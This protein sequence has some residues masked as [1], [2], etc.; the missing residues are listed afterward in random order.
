MK[1]STRNGLAL[2]AVVGCLLGTGGIATLIL[3][4]CRFIESTSDALADATEGSA[5]SDVFR[6]S[7][8]LA[9]S[10]R[11]YSPA[12][13]HY[14]GRSVSAQIL[15]RYRVHPDQ[16]LQDYVNLVG[17]AVLAAPE[18]QRTLTG[19]HFIVLEG[20]EVQG[21][22][23]P[24]GFV[25]VTEGAVRA[26]QDEDELAALL[27]HEIAHVSLEHGI[28]AVKAATRQKAGV[29]LG[30]GAGNTAAAASGKDAQQLAELTSVFGNVVDEITTELLV[31]GYGR[32][33]ELAADATATTYLRSSGYARSALAAYLRALESHG[34]GG[35]GGWGATHPSPSERLN[36]LNAA[37]LDQ[38]DGVAGRDVRAT[39]FVAMLGRR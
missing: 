37:G 22:S 4:G 39:R 16:S 28:L 30:K 32:D 5:V 1:T 7:A 33:L 36:A 23:A 34:G 20:Q 21:V 29:L 6:G 27:A 11:E 26:A 24:G 8:R 13:E 10:Y 17:M 12:E 3:G 38:P 9:E 14:I 35:S 15:A 19:Y 31:N 2:V 25:F 18:A